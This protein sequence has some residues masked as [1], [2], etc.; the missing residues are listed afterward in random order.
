M[1]RRPFRQLVHALICSAAFIAIGG[2]YLLEEA[3]YAGRTLTS[4]EY[5]FR[6]SVAV[7]SRFNTPDDR[8]FFLAIDSASISLSELV[9]KTLFADVPTGS[10]EHRA[11]TLMAGYRRDFCTSGRRH[12]PPYYFVC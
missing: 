8:L 6:D 11:L 1:L 10:T 12:M 5:F 4:W 3:G 9:L 7:R 2:L